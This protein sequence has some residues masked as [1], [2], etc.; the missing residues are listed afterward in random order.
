MFTCFLFYLL[1]IWL[2]VL[3]VVS[4]RI[5]FRRVPL[6]SIVYISAPSLFMRF[7]L[8]PGYFHNS[9]GV[10]DEPAARNA[11]PSYEAESSVSSFPPVPH[12]RAH[13]SRLNFGIRFGRRKQ[14]GICKLWHL[15]SPLSL[16]L[17]TQVSFSFFGAYLA[18]ETFHPASCIL[19]FFDV[20]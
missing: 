20:L 3:H 14:P 5:F 16:V 10:N 19:L 6:L 11:L 1:P 7:R 18:A 8:F 17:F 4:S 15:S 13:S 12:A 2:V 9:F